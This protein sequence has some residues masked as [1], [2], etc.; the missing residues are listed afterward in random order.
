MGNIQSK[1][2]VPFPPTSNTPGC[3]RSTHAGPQQRQL[4]VQANSFFCCPTLGRGGL[5]HQ[6][7]DS[8]WIS[9]LRTD[10][11]WSTLHD[12]YL[13]P[14]FSNI[15]M[16]LRAPCAEV[17]IQKGNPHLLLAVVTVFIFLSTCA[18][19]A[20]RSSPLPVLSFPHPMGSRPS[21]D[22]FRYRLPSN[23]NFFLG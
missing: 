19:R 2:L 20:A 1:A 9:R 7:E 17:R 8:T 5:Q 4:H 13:R 12:P 23:L 10:G 22:K 6:N 11:F 18:Y 15:K 14:H 3:P 16:G 21:F